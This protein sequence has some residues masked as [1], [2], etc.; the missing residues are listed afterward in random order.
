MVLPIALYLVM[1]GKVVAGVVFG[2]FGI[3]QSLILDNIVKT[4]LIGSQARMHDLLV[5]LSIL[6]G[7]GAFGPIGILYGP[8][9]AVAFLTFADLYRRTYRHVAAERITRGSVTY[10]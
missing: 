5:F 10:E 9:L 4:R 1:T 7:L 6:G 2:S 8:L 3:L